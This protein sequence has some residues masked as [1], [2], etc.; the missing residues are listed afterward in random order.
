MKAA[1][2]D[3][4]LSSQ[5]FYR[6]LMGYIEE[7]GVGVCVCVCFVIRQSYSWPIWLSAHFTVKSYTLL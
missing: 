5:C 3:P 6:P 1:K 2:I 7:R 4:R